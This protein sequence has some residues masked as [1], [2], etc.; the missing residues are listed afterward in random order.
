MNKTIKISELKPGM[1]IRLPHA[2]RAHPFLRNNFTVTSAKQIQKMIE[3]GIKEVIIDEQKGIPA[4]SI[5]LEEKQPEKDPPPEVKIVPDKLN[6][7]LSDK[8]IS[9]ALRAEAIHLH[10]VDMMKNLWVN[11]TGENIAQ[12]KE[13]VFG[14]VDLMLADDDIS[15]RLL[16]LTSY[17]YNTYVHSVNVG[18][19]AI[20]LAKVLFIKENKHDMHA[21]GAGFFLHDI[22]K[23]YVN[24]TIIKKPGKL[25]AEEMNIMRKHPGMG[26]KLLTD[27]KQINDES[28]LIVLQHHERHNGTGY[29]RRMRGED[30]H[31]YGRICSIADVFDALV[32][33]RP[34]KE[35]LKPFEA[36][37]IMK[38]E[39]LDHFHKEIFEKF[40]LLFK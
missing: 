3:H 32:S 11:P 35:Q 15:N 4:E 28:R 1:Y 12:F 23:V 26:F 2:W 36:L 38:D 21:L 40:V 8:Q 20:S 13:G 24:E 19:L 34:Y 10:A 29:P 7:V 39:M 22:G 14:V 37:K 27:T 6:A 18:I 17:D 31:V 25:S 9:P 33:K 5:V 16:N 30:I